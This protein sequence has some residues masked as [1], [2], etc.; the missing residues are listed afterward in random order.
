LVVAGGA[1]RSVVAQ[2]RLVF[3]V[4][5]QELD[6]RPSREL[7]PGGEVEVRD[8]FWR[9]QGATRLRVESSDPEAFLLMRFLPADKRS[10][11]LVLDLH[12]LSRRLVRDFQYGQASETMVGGRIVPRPDFKIGQGVTT[13]LSGRRG[14][15]VEVRI[16]D[17]AVA[18][19]RLALRDDELVL[20]AIPAKAGGELSGRNFPVYW[21]EKLSFLDYTLLGAGWLDNG[22]GELLLFEHFALKINGFSE[23][24]ASAAAAR[25]VVRQQLVRGRSLGLW[26]E[27][28]AG[29]FTQD[30]AD[31]S[32]E[33]EGQATVAFGITGQFRRGDWGAAL[34]AASING[35]LLTMVLGG[36]QFSQSFSLLLEWQSLLG[37]SGY[38]VGLGIAF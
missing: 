9:V 2:D 18:E 21:G 11:G 23:D 25:L 22:Y 33:N 15:V 19:L 4:V 34:H 8:E 6:I 5:F 10:G 37:F 1:A 31:P 24:N 28:G 14:E 27:G 35:P 32:E 12:L 36:W 30:P 16:Q 38:G 26:V 17:D 29:F 3:R 7:T 20:R 13:E